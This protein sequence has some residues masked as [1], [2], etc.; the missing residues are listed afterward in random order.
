MNDFAHPLPKDA[1]DEQ[2]RILRHVRERTYL[3]DEQ[4]PYHGVSHPDKVWAQAEILMGRCER[5]DIPVDGNALRHAIEL[6][7]AL[8]HM[9]ARML[10]YESAENM[11]AAFTYR[12]LIDGGASQRVAAKVHD[13]IMATNPDVHP[14][15]PEEVIIRAADLSNIGSTFTEF[16]SA[17]LALHREAQLAK[18][19]E[20]P[21]ANWIR[22]SFLYLERF[23]WPMLELTPASKDD[24]GRSVFHTNAVRNMATLW[25]ETFGEH[26]PISV[27][28]FPTGKVVPTPHDSQEFYIAI[29]PDEGCRKEALA[30]LAGSALASDGAAFVV[31]GAH[32]AF[33]IPD[34]FCDK[35]I[36]HDPTVETLGEALRI[37]RRGGTVV[38]DLPNN[39]DPR[40]L[41]QA[42]IFQTTIARVSLDGVPRISLV[43]KKDAAL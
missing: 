9:P 14:S 41:Q 21:F 12:F 26:T 30:E 23:M 6:H 19:Q 13:I 31:P 25:R 3:T 22:G 7:D 4:S 29:H 10:G 34:E 1:P 5:Y 40:L 20:V 15:T 8:S 27:E 32:G 18:G 38:L 17:S 16:R 36:C 2:R 37:T 35:V 11:A 33:P 24:H 28:F 43:L 42:Q 39:V